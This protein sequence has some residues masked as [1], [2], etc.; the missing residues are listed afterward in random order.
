MEN[1]QNFA[2]DY[3]SGIGYRSTGLHRHPFHELIYV[4]EG[5]LNFLVDDKLYKAS[6]NCVILFKE[7]RL[8]TSEVDRNSVYTR[9][10]LNFRQ[11]YVSELIDYELLCDCFSADCTVLPVA[12][13]ER[14]T[15]GMLFEALYRSYEDGGERSVYDEAVCRHLFAAILASVSRMARE[16]PS[17][18]G[19]YIDR[20]YIADVVRYIGERLDKKLLIGDIAGEFFVSRAKLVNDFKAACGITIG[21]YITAQ[22]MKLAKKLLA[23]GFDVGSCAT[24]SGFANTCHFIRT[25][26]AHTGVTPLKYAHSVRSLRG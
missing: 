4:K 8:H 10:N 25:F 7:K 1:G 19:I 20:S 23:D 3:F 18:A 11:K 12:P 16:N 24:R 13:E 6:G 5:N 17:A 9:Y 21:E 2:M 26:K 22:R 15:F 14:E